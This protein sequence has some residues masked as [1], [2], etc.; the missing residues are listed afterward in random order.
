MI[1]ITKL[2]NASSACVLAALVLAPT[3]IAAPEAA[4]GFTV[5]A[6]ATA[7]ETVPAT[8]GADDI[9][10]LGGNV[11]VGWQNGVGTKGEPNSST[12]QTAG[13]VVEYDPAGQVLGTWSL[14]GKIDGLG[15]DPARGRLIATVNEDG[16]SSLYTITPSAPA[17]QQV[18]HYTYSPA[19][20]SGTSGGV[21][22][23]GGTD[24]VTVHGGQIYLSASNPTP[25][26]ATALFHVHLDNATHTASLAPTYAD[27]AIATDAATG[28]SVKLALTDPDSNANVP[29]SSPRFAGQLVLAAQGDKQLV[30]ARRIQGDEPQL[31]RLALTKEAQPAGVDDVRWSA[32][33]TG[34]LLVVDRGAGTIYSVTGPF[35]GGEPFG[36]LDT[37]GEA[38]QHNEVERVDLRSGAMTPFITG[39][40]AGKGLLWLPSPASEDQG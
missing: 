32:G 25:E 18:R 26:N 40:S 15:G 31:T 24:A 7:P 29:L 37:V 8:T 36:S 21:L 27:N 2:L 39:L 5:S 4:P 22:T 19:P 12:G 28:E 13:T 17:A 16:N 33:Q 10:G 11:F 38:E 30:F 23:G 3:A 34:R 9:A 6:F 14:T 35:L 1:P 20:D